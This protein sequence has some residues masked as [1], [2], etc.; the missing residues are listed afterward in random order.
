MTDTEKHPACPPLPDKFDKAE[1]IIGEKWGV[2]VDE[3]IT[4]AHV[5]SPRY[6]VHVADRLHPG[7]TIE[8]CHPQW[9]ALLRVFV[10]A[11][12]LVVVRLVHANVPAAAEP[13][14]QPIAFVPGKG[15]R[16]RGAVEWHPTRAEAEAAAA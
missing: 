4:L 10:A 6:W 13:Q 14:K 16:K 3:P 5:L 9:D 2:R 8:V 12:G 1:N 7:D 15:Y 11:D